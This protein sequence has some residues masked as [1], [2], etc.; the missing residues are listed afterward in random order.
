MN[1]NI[2]KVIQRTFTFQRLEKDAEK[3]YF[4]IVSQISDEK[5][6]STLTSIMQDEQKH[7]KACSK[8]LEIFKQEYPEEYMEAKI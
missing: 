7:Y 5:I 1:T 3:M 4:D 6:I 8:I 2:V